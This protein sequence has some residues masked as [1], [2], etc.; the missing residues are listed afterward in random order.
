MCE[1]TMKWQE[2]SIRVPWEFVEPISYLFGR[3]GHG[4]SMEKSEDALILMRSY[5]PDTSKRRLARIEVGVNLVRLLQPMTELTIEP[6]EES[7]WESAW[8]AHFDLLRVGRRLVIKPSW[9]D[10]A[11][12]AGDLTIE[13]DPGMAF[14][15]GYHPT[16]RMCLEALEEL[17][18]PGMSVLDLG[19]GS[20]ILS[21]AAVRLGAGVVLALD[22]DATAV[23]AARRNFK[24]GCFTP[25]ARASRGTL[26]HQLAADAGFD[27]AVANIS[28]KVILD[29]AP[30][31]CRAL[32]PGGMLIASGFMEDRMGEVE[33]GLAEAGLV[34]RETH[35]DDEWAALVLVR[36]Q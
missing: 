3:Y 10:H 2:L 25:Q 33:G 26:P 36:S 24:A 18:Q 23:T 21:M 34:R 22:K 15:T 20:G 8:K 9:I 35:R 4:L 11:P 32:R 19:T 14:G 6:L 27:L 7:D 31:L 5:L 28:S 1:Q 12:V 17:V 29:R 16:T 30:Y 13:L